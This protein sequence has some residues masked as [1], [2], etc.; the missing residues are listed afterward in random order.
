MGC[1]VDCGR[2]VGPPWSH[3]GLDGQPDGGLGRIRRRLSEH[4]MAIRPSDRY[5]GCDVDR[6]RA[7]EKYLV[8]FHRERIHQGL[9]NRLIDTENLA[10]FRCRSHAFHP[11]LHTASHARGYGSKMK[12]RIID[13]V[14]ILD[15]SHELTPGEDADLLQVELERL[16]AEGHKRFLVNL[17]GVPFLDSSGL[18]RLLAVK[19]A[20]LVANAA[21]KLLQPQTAVLSLIALTGVERVFECFDDEDAAIRSF[22]T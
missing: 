1:D 8:H 7:V 3:G 16:L 13:Q 6:K 22:E 10:L 4:G 14:T 18:G 9:G 20:V 21:L 15:V 19:K 5:V 2:A 12:T 11:R 17:R